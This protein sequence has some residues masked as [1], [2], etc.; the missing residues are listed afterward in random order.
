MGIL[1]ERRGSWSPPSCN[2]QLGFHL[3]PRWRATS[4]LTVSTLSVQ[5]RDATGGPSSLHVG[6][7][8]EE[9]VPARAWARDVDALLFSSALSPARIREM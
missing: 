8:D 9:V 2:F 6:H 4:T 3:A 1:G 7:T 5:G